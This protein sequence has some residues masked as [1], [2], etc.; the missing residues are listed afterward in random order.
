LLEQ[1]TIDTLFSLDEAATNY[2]ILKDN[3]VPTAMLWMCS[4]HGVCLTDPGDQQLPGTAALAW[5]AR[6]VK[7]DTSAKTGPAFRYVDQNGVEHSA[8]QSPV[9]GQQLYFSGKGQLTLAAGGG[10]GPATATGSVGAL[11]GIALPIT[12]GKATH[13]LNV[14]VAFDA[15]VEVL[16]AP[17]LSLTYSGTSPPGNKPTRVFAQLVDDSTGI[18]VGNQITPI[19][20]TLDGKEHSTTLPLEIVVFTAKPGS[21]LTLQLVAT[22]VA[23]AEPR[24]GGTIDFQSVHLGLPTVTGVSPRLSSFGSRRTARRALATRS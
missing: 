22:T 3:G 18:V 10:S 23:Y 9:D 4:G 5:L 14:P 6:Y 11:G 2:K 21:K 12:P 19:Q 20:V 24:L 8:N 13:A 16:G 7:N 15:G 1:G 17:R